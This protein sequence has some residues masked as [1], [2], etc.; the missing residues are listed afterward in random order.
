MGMIL[1]RG[2]SRAYHGG[3]KDWDFAQACIVANFRHFIR[4]RRPKGVDLRL[5]APARPA[6]ANIAPAGS[7]QTACAIER[8]NKTAS[9]AAS[10]RGSRARRRF[11]NTGRGGGSSSLTPLILSSAIRASMI[12]ENVTGNGV[13]GRWRSVGNDSTTCTSEAQAESMARFSS[14]FRLA[15]VRT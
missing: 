7:L 3:C 5:G 6:P 15:S 14:R 8:Q 11:P 9:H 1:W 4:D 10:L 13:P 12:E 2:F